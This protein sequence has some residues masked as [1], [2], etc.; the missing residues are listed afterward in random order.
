LA[1]A[2]AAEERPGDRNHRDP[3]CTHSDNPTLPSARVTLAMA[4]KQTS[5]LAE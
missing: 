2:P 5:I 1:I 3:S 4:T